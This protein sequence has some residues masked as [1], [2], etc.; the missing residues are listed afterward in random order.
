[1]LSD[2]S[3]FVL[4]AI[5]V[6]GSTALWLTVNKNLY[7]GTFTQI[8]K[9]PVVLSVLG[10]LIAYGAL[11]LGA[12]LTTGIGSSI[13]IPFVNTIF[14]GLSGKVFNGRLMATMLLFAIAYLFWNGIALAVFTDYSPRLAIMDVIWGI[15]LGGIVGYVG[16][17]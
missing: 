15:A 5:T 1:M 10:L 14:P 16:Q 17:L 4:I 8:Q 6:L 2:F 12:Y 3:R 11:I 13:Q 9:S 7:L